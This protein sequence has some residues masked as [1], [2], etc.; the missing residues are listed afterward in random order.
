MGIL[1]SKA[2]GPRLSTGS[3]ITF[4]TRPS[5]PRPRERKWVALIIA[6]MP[7]HAVGRFHG[8]TAHS[9]FADVLLHF[10]DEL[11]GKDGKRR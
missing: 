9:A 11:M 10:E 5:V 2:I 4:I 7:A 3:P 1:F 8:N 6:F